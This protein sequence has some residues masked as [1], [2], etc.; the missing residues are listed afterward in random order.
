MSRC[1]LC[2]TAFRELDKKFGLR[3]RNGKWDVV[4]YGPGVPGP[5]HGNCAKREARKRNER[6][7]K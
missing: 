1:G 7:A 6:K 3:E 2:Q 4:P 5:Y